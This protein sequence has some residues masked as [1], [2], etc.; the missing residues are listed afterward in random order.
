MDGAAYEVGMT[1]DNVDWKPEIERYMQSARRALQTSQIDLEVG[2]YAASIN[3]SYYAAFY[4]ANALLALLGLQ[5]SKHSAVQAILHQRFVKPGLVEVE[6]G[7]LYD[8]L[9]ERRM[10]SD[11]ETLGVKDPNLAQWALDAARSF[12]TRVEQFLAS[13][14]A[15]GSL[16]EPREVYAPPTSR[17]LTSLEANDRAA[18][19]TFVERLYDQF[20]THIALTTLFGSKARGD[21]SPDSDIDILVVADSDDWQFESQVNGLASEAG[22][23]YDVLLN[24]HLISQA[25]WQDFSRRRAAFYLNVR[26]DG[27]EL[28]A[29]ITNP[30]SA[31]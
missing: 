6:Y 7:K 2:D 21:S 8:D 16:R 10:K 9:F 4:A 24:V 19:Q 20:G 27:I 3:R 11:Y 28:R 1:T 23:E 29:P 14:P 25:R 12:V 15:D 17:D 5:R 18:V 26:R 22:Y 13:P 30:P 31:I